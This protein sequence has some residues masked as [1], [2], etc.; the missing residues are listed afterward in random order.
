[1]PTDEKE[2]EEKQDTG[3][4]SAENEGAESGNAG[5]TENQPDYSMLLETMRELQANQAAMSAQLKAIS[6]AQSVIVDAGAVVREVPASQIDTET[7]PG[8]D[9]FISLDKMD[10][11]I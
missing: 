11:S 10:L 2:T 9:G 7:D 1:M 5:G 4:G 6:D 3:T 8:N